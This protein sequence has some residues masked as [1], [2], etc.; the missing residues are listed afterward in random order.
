MTRVAIC[1]LS[2]DTV[3]ADFATSLVHLIA[4]TMMTR[5]DVQITTIN[6]K[7]TI[8]SDGRNI[9]VEGAISAGCTHVLFIDSDMAF[10]HDALL[11]LLDRDRLVI[12]AT[13]MS[14]RSHPIHGH[15]LMHQEKDDAPV[16]LGSDIRQV[17][18]MPT[19]FLLINLEVFKTLPKP[20]FWFGYTQNLN[21]I[22]EDYAFCSGVLKL[23]LDIWLDADLSK[24]IGHTGSVTFYPGMFGHGTKTDS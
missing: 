4:H 3:H 5:P 21:V 8:I 17:A 6:T 23:G 14:R 19:G 15:S 7:C 11:R 16:S 9:A 2:G 13:Y 20:W 18:H 10:P 12:G 1:F 24:Q 22:G